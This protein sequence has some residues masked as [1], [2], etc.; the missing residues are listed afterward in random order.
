MEIIN[1]YGLLPFEAARHMR[2]HGTETRTRVSHLMG[3]ERF[4]LELARIVYIFG[5]STD[6]MYLKQPIPAY[7]CCFLPPLLIC[8][9][10]SDSHYYYY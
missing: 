5:F 9:L 6:L 2:A 1:S 4:I 8:T 10:Q 7:S 3:S